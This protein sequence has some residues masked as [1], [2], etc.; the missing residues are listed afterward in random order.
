MVPVPSGWAPKVT[1]L[2][3]TDTQVC[4]AHAGVGMGR[5]TLY[6]NHGSVQSWKAKSVVKN[7]T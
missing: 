3:A 2:P 7:L 5:G 1:T 6:K 4:Q